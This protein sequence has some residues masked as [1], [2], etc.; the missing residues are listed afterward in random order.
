ME[1]EASQSLVACICIVVTVAVSSLSSCGHYNPWVLVL[2]AYEDCG[3]VVF[4]I[5]RAIVAVVCVAHTFL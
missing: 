4:L 5:S 2:S 1:P 3:A